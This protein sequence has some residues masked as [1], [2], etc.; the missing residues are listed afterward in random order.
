MGFS[1]SVLGSVLL[2]AF[3]HRQLT[4]NMHNANSRFSPR[5]TI[6][7]DKIQVPGYSMT[8]AER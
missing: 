7:T 1:F 3:F 5:F 6:A 8:P 4:S 2:L